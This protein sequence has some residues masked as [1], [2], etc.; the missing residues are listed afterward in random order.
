[1]IGKVI[2]VILYTIFFQNASNRNVALL[3][4]ADIS[5]EAKEQLLTE[6][7]RASIANDRLVLF[8]FIL[9]VILAIISLLF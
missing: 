7:T 2:S 4:N 6:L 3:M 8:L 9:I 5:K 1:M